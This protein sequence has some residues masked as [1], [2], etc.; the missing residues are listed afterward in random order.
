M[1][2]YWDSSALIEATQTK[3]LRDRLRNEKGITRSHALA[4][5][6][7]TLTG[8]PFCRTDHEGAVATLENLY[9][10]LEFTDLT[11]AEVLAALKTCKRRGVR[12]GQ[13]H[14]LLHAAAA[15]KAG[16]KELL[17][18]DVNDFKGLPEKARVVVL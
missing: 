13:V 11:P 3:E 9:A 16:V 10:D 7:A 2:A 17:T 5:V 4:E 6:F 12:G 8:N 1:K 18:V 15:D 14:D